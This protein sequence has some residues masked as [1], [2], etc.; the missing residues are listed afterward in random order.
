MLV[1]ILSNGR[2]SELI[3]GG[4]ELSDPMETYGSN[5]L[6]LPQSQLNFLGKIVSLW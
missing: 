4:D 2:Y 6:S 5:Y 1:A 3:Q